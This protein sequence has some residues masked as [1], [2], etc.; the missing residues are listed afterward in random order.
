[1][2]LNEYRSRNLDE[3]IDK[4]FPLVLAFFKIHHFKYIGIVLT[5]DGYCTRE[6][7]MRIVIVKEAFNRK[8]SLLTSKLNIEIKKKLVRC[9][10]WSTALYGIE[11][12]GELYGE[13]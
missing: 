11:I 1:M 3:F 10:V 2:L 6:L 9:Y 7:K 5:R 12:R 4:L 13:L 8:L